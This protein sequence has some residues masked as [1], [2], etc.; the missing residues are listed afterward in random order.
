[1]YWQSNGENDDDDDD[2]RSN[3]R[4]NDTIIQHV[5]QPL[6]GTQPTTTTPRSI[7]FPFVFPIPDEIP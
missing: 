5:V 6:A 3:T 7:G 4:E 1:V 2:D